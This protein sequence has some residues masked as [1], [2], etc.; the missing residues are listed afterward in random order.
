MRKV[1]Y[2]STQNN[3]LTRI[4]DAYYPVQNTILHHMYAQNRY[5]TIYITSIS[6]V[7]SFSDTTGIYSH[8]F[9]RT[10]RKMS[11]FALS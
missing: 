10:Q 2:F 7:P 8:L 6:F 4:N 5:H 1:W 11:G 3:E 9:F